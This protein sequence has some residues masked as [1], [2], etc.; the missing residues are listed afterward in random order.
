MGK[1]AKQGA[2]PPRTAGHA[3]FLTG[4]LLQ[5]TLLVE[6]YLRLSERD[7]DLPDCGDSGTQRTICGE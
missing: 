5:G 7:R 3:G 2:R 1:G 6:E 4:R